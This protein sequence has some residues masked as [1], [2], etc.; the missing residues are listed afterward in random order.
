MSDFSELQEY[1][2]RR[3]QE[4]RQ[5]QIDLVE[6]QRPKSRLQQENEN[7]R[8]MSDDYAR[9]AAERDGVAEDGGGE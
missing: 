7:R 3:A 2:E 4:D 5:F 9:K 8:L 6:R 1:L